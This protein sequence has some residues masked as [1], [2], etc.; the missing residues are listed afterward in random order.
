M[1]IKKAHRLGVL[2][3]MIVMVIGTI[4]SFAALILAQGDTTRLAN[5]YQ[6]ALASYKKEQESYTKVVDA[7]NDELSSKYYG[8]FT[9]YQDKVGTFPIDSVD[10]LTTEDLLVGDGEEITGTTKFSAYYLGWDANGNKFSGGNTIDAEKQKLTTPL[11][12]SAGLD[13]ASL[14]DGWKEGIKGMRIGGVRLLTI[15]SGKAYGP[16]GSTDSSTGQTTIAPNMPLKF[17]VMAI[18]SPPEVAQ[19][20]AL[21]NATNDYYKAAAAYYGTQ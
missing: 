9:Q 3:I 8:T 6:K 12:V 7:Q 4:G 13:N 16:N 17:I 19:P 15:P 14:I 2:I 20:E 11:A 21:V 18:P 1:A 5:A 10:S